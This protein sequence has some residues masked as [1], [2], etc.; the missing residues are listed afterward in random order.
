MT[1]REMVARTDRNLGHKAPVGPAS[2][3][4]DLMQGWFEEGACDGWA[5]TPTAMPEAFDAVCRLLIPELQRRG[6]ARTEYQGDT[7]RDHLGLKRPP[8]PERI[9]TPAT[10]AR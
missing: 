7:L 5:I 3:V 6:L 10:T 8:S 1:L 2:D 4:A 9:P